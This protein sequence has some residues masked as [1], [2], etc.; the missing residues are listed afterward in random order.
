MEKKRVA[1]ICDNNDKKVIARGILEALPE[2]FGIPET[3]EDYIL[4]S[5]QQPFFVA[6]ENQHAI[7]F[8]CLKET[9]KDTVELAVMGF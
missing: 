1:Q 4:E 9:G 2:W 5:V 6:K 8:L 3:R 7:G